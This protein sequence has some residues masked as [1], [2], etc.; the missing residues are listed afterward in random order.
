MNN[1]R[2]KE[3]Q[4]FEYFSEEMLQAQDKLESI[5]LGEILIQSDS[6]YI[7]ASE[8]QPELFT[9]SKHQIICNALIGL[10]K[11]NKAIDLVTIS[12]KIMEEGRLEELG[13]ISFISELT[14]SIVSASNLEHHFKILQ[15]NFLRRNIVEG[16]NLIKSRSLS[17][18][19]DVFDLIQEHNQMYSDLLN[20]VITRGYQS[21]S[22]VHKELIKQH[23][24][25]SGTQEFSGVPT[26]LK[27]LDN[28]TNGWQKSDLIIIAGRPAMGKTSI[29]VIFAMNP[30][31][32][33]NIPVAF[34]SL[35]MSSEQVV[36]RMQSIL[37]EYNVSRLVKKQLKGYELPDFE[38]RTK[39]LENAPIYIDDTP[40]LSIF[41]LKSKAR[42]LVR[43]KGVKMLVVDYLQLM[44]SSGGRNQSR[45]QEIGEIS[46]GLK[47]IAKELDIPVI[48]LSQL[49]RGVEARGGEKKPQLSDL[50]ESGQIE[51]DAD[52][53]MFCYRPEYYEMND[54]EI[55]GQVYD[56]RGL[57]LLLV[58]K[59][60]NGS[61]GD[62]PLKFI[63][64]NTNIVNHPNFLP[65][66]E[67]LQQDNP[68]SAL[69]PN[70]DFSSDPH[71]NFWSEDEAIF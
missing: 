52:M 42:Q 60:R 64:E 38:A 21:V 67:T 63:K 2:K 69:K 56:T 31:I 47:A 28:L 35:E 59:H 51:Q 36:S 53:V 34:F 14:S 4:K 1:R 5:V 11:E 17:N 7:V 15:E 12:R 57:F 65:Q 43:E 48:A 54:Y 22:D 41:E 46:R 66:S 9:N 62:V 19:E 44:Q 61:L 40:S 70:S 26:D 8:L 29:S 18:S 13:G 24:L 10:F 23:I 30:A 49:S 58:A 6:I 25:L 71:S 68:F 45:E 50:R 16:C 32:N 39:N 27:L 20:S 37:S 3:I 33:H 55:G